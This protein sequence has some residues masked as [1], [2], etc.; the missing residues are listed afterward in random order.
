MICPLIKDSKLWRMCE[1]S[2][3]LLRNNSHSQTCYKLMY[4]VVYFLVHMIRTAGKNNYISAL[5]TSL[6]YYFVRFFSNIIDMCLHSLISLVYSRRYFALDVILLE[7]FSHN[8]NN[9][10]ASVEV[11]VRIFEVFGIK[12]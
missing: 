7:R 6:T 2:N 4:A 11:H 8:L 9:I 5:C 12:A 1:R 10:F 3:A